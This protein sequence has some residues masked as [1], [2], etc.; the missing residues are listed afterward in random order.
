MLTSTPI[1]LPILSLVLWTL[2]VQV[3][4]IVTRLP[5]IGAANLGPTAGERTAELAAQLPAQVQW[6]ADN[7]N[8][9]MEQPTI[10]YAMALALALAGDG[11]GLNLTLAW[12]YVGSRVIHSV[13]HVTVNKV[14]VRFM[15]FAFG[16]LMLAAMVVNGMMGLL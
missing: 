2:I 8:H 7:Y 1:L 16:S 14:M 11:S 9:L 10:F 12:L 5:A 13:V 6:K 15:F 4:M 3:W